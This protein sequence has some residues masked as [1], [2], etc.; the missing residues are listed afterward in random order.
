M[1]IQM[2]Q[3]R[4]IWCCCLQCVKQSLQMTTGNFSEYSTVRKEYSERLN[5][6]RQFKCNPSGELSR[7]TNKLESQHSEF[8][9]TS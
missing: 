5:Y 8:K 1:T 4:H 2:Y 9:P 6:L 3:M 7:F